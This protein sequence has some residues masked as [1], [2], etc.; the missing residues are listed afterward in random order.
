MI[1]TNNTEIDAVIEALTEQRNA[2]LDAVVMLTSK[3]R[4]QEVLTAQL[5]TQ[6]D[7]VLKPKEAKE[8]P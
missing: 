8:T 4:A 6:L 5:R 3:L 1:K 2:A 7:E